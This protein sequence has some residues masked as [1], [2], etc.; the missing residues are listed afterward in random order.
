MD[1][2][3]LKYFIKQTDE[4][5]NKIDEEFERVNQKVD[6]LLLANAR[7]T[8]AAIVISALLTVVI[9]AA[10]FVIERLS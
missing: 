2:Q 10:A 9:Q 6:R 7:V 5:F 4:R 1:E 3:L 8:G